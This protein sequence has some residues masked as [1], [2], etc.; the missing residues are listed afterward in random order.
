[1]NSFQLLIN[2]LSLQTCSIKYVAKNQK[3]NQQCYAFFLNQSKHTFIKKFENSF[4]FV[5]PQQGL[6]I[7]AVLFL[8]SGLSVVY[9]PRVFP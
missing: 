6:R 9:Q 3:K 1:M 7:L 8:I 4:F 5:Y 2:F